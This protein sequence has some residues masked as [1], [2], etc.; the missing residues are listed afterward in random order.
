[1]KKLLPLLHLLALL[2]LVTRAQQ[3]FA[4]SPPTKLEVRLENSK[5]VLYFTPSTGITSHIILR[6]SGITSELP[7][8]PL[9]GIALWDKETLAASATS[10]ELAQGTNTYILYSLNGNIFSEPKKI[11]VVNSDETISNSI[12]TDLLVIL[13]GT[14]KVSS[15]RTLT[16]NTSGTLNW[17]GGNL[18]NEGTV[19]LQGSFNIL[20]GKAY[21]NGAGLFTIAA[22]G[23]LKVFGT[24]NLGNAQNDKLEVLKDGVLTIPS[25]GSLLMSK[26]G[27]LIVRKEG[28]I[29]VDGLIDVSNDIHVTSNFDADAL[30][31]FNSGSK[32]ILRNNKTAIPKAIWSTGSTVEWAGLELPSGIKQTFANFIWN[33]AGQ[34]PNLDLGCDLK[35]TGDLTIRSTNNK[36]LNIGSC[37]YVVGKNLIIE[38]RCDTRFN[39]KLAVKGSITNTGNLVVTGDMTVDGNIT[40]ENGATI[41]LPKK[42]KLGLNGLGG[43]FTNAGTITLLS[44]FDLLD[45]SGKLEHNSTSNAFPLAKITYVN[46]G[47]VNNGTLTTPSGLEELKV[48]GGIIHNNTSSPFPLATETTVLSG[49]ITSHGP[50]QASTATNLLQVTGGITHNSN[51]IFHLAKK[52]DIKSGGLINKGNM[53]P[54][55]GSSFEELYIVG[56]SQNMEGAQMQLPTKTITFNGDL[57]NAGT[58]T[59]T[60][61][62]TLTITGKLDLVA[63]SSSSLPSA[64]ISGALSNA[65]SLSVKDQLTVSGALQNLANAQMLLAAQTTVLGGGL[66][67]NGTI[68]APATFSVLKVT[69]G[70]QHNASG[71]FPL[72]SNTTVTS[73]GIINKGIMSPVSETDFATLSVTGNIDNA[74][75]ASIKLAKSTTTGGFVNNGT[76]SAVSGFT[77][78]TVGGKLEHNALGTFPLATQTTVSSGGIISNGPMTAPTTFNVL[79]VT[80]GIQHNTTD[81]FPL[82]TQTTVSSG[83]ITSN[84]P[85]TATGSFTLLDVTGGIA[86]NSN[87]MFHLANSTTIKSGGLTNKGTMLPL[88]AS[89]FATLSVAGN[90]DNAT[91]ANLTLA[92]TTNTT[93]GSLINN[94]SVSAVSGFTTLSLGG[95][96]DHISTGTFP[97][98]TQTTVL[99][100]GITSN[101]PMQASAATTL[102]QVTGGIVHNS[103]G[104]FQL[105]EKTDIKSGGLLNKGTMKPFA[106]TSD[107]ETLIVVGNTQN[108]A[109]AQLQLPTIT[110]TVTGDLLNSGTI[111]SS[112]SGAL[113]VSGKLDVANGAS[114]ALPKTATIGGILTNAGSVSGRDAMTFGGALQNLAGAQL[115]MALQTTVSSGGLVNSGTVT[116]PNAFSMLRVTGGIQHNSTSSAF[117]LAKYTYVTSG[118][119]TSNGPI[120]AIAGFN[121]LDVSGGITHNAAGDFHLAMYNYIQ[122]GG[123]VNKGNMAP[124]VASEYEEFKIFAGDLKIMSG[125]QFQQSTITTAITGDLINSGT[126]TSTASGA[127]TVTGKMDVAAGASASLSKTATISGNLLNAGTVTSRDELTVNGPLTR[128]TG[129]LSLA[130]KTTILGDLISSGTLQV[131]EQLYLHGSLEAPTGSSFN[132]LATKRELYFKQIAQDKVTDF[133]FSKGMAAA[134]SIQKVAIEA[135]RKVQLASD[136][137]LSGASAFDVASNSALYLGNNIIFT[138]AGASGSNFT[139]NANATLTIG[140]T[141][142]ISANGNSG[143]IRTDFRNFKSGAFYVYNGTKAQVTGTGLPAKVDQLLIIDNPTTV[144]LSQNLINTVSLNLKRGKFDLNG[145]KVTIEKDLITETGTIEGGGNSELAFIGSGIM[146]VPAGTLSI[147]NIKASAD[148]KLSMVGNLTVDRRLYMDEGVLYTK[149][150]KVILQRNANSIL[151]SILVE[152]KEEFS[153]GFI[154]G[155]I[156]TELPTT[157]AGLT[158]DINGIGISV[159]FNGKAGGTTYVTRR[160]GTLLDKKGKVK[161][162]NRSYQIATTENNGLNAAVTFQYMV[163]EFTDLLFDNQLKIYKTADG[164]NFEKRSNTIVNTVEKSLTISSV[165]QFNASFS[166]AS[167]SGI[168]ASST[169]VTTLGGN[170][171]GLSQ[172]AD[173]LSGVKFGSTSVTQSSV[174]APLADEKP[175]PSTYAAGSE[176]APLPVELISFSAVLNQTGDAEL[177]WATASE[178]NNSHF[179]VQRSED[180]KLW[181]IVNQVTGKGNASTTSRY[182]CLDSDFA[183]VAAPVVFYRLKQVDFDGSYAFSKVVAVEQVAQAA[184]FSSIYLNKATNNLEIR[185]NNLNPDLPVHVVLSDIKGRTY[186]NKQISLDKRSGTLTIPVSGAAS[187]MLVARVASGTVFLSAKMIK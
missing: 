32:Y 131:H 9:T 77:T 87:G 79:N 6:K 183:T 121:M 151:G 74:V 27:E 98:A 26:F 160:T 112:A 153:K 18:K 138:A 25:T 107:F 177:S 170:R 90:I 55:A 72:A 86:H 89:T 1:M 37:D 63:G 75:G 8:S 169:G 125:G 65:G 88:S 20:N 80:G 155:T 36:Q 7:S 70:I 168:R 58:L 181:D 159:K 57:S 117:P 108:A 35:V 67:N 163:D 105:A 182:K 154:S 101:G 81:T 140:H 128:N 166:A 15:G 104:T 50:V 96:L 22:G 162:A 49:G 29:R 149:A 46:G 11:V 186:I 141:E 39:G 100:G 68:T 161:F 106:T 143:A 124:P 119:I 116:A 13:N 146:Q 2:L 103:T 109:G 144:T 185:Y 84:G 114:V 167:S 28:I 33:S 16:I 102:L 54:L 113:T 94:G 17:L 24:Y 174:T 78:L 127:L 95:K 164:E 129:S 12:A 97:L 82:A 21:D 76:V 165:D 59:H 47:L 171:S 31:T 34:G 147:L 60:G 148:A 150:Y 91:G 173:N 41:Q 4:Q 85:M 99:S 136:I 19:V 172:S 152:D 42:I 137:Q 48:A 30:I 64:T 38:N 175:T 126:I 40:N 184:Q 178:T 92:K 71:T 179:E 3:G 51:K 187:G 134:G 10:I 142:G 23:N 69:G 52:T 93:T 5:P 120:T 133:S 123:V 66:V 53:M 115:Q 56:N 73:G 176:P 83:G 14:T 45:I 132:P 156:E 61:S 118:G 44:S 139:V 158:Y 145:N 130:K 157:A 110:T 135:G 111:T 62:G 43:N 180:G 122:S